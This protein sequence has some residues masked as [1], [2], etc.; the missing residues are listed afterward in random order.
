M[1]MS[2]VIGSAPLGEG[3]GERQAP[4]PSLLHVVA[5]VASALDRALTAVTSVVLA[6]ALLYS[7]YALWDT[8]RIYEGASVDES[9]LKYKPSPNAA[10]GNNF[11]ELLAINPDVC[12]WLTVDGTHIDYPVVQG[13]DNTTYVN[14][15][16]YG[17]FSLSGSI[18]LDARNERDFS[19]AYS[20]IYGHHME[21]NVMFGELA[22]FA[23]AEY[24]E[25]HPLGELMLPDKTYRIEFFA[26]MQADA[27]DEQVFGPGELTEGEVT[28]LLERARSESLQYRDIGVSGN[29]RVLA[30]STCSDAATNARTIV[31]GRLVETTDGLGGVRNDD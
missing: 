24:F 17:E 9:L 6:L 31:L 11:A 19:D 29:D 30:L 16:V 8:W 26:C 3:A 1:R 23:E 15:D 13:D 10:G 14:T 22:R 21:G 25:E 28:A 7:G 2:R 27:Y 12:A 5:G 4:R 20:L 18:F